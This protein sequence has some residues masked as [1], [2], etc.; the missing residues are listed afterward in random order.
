MN[1]LRTVPDTGLDY[2]ERQLEQKLHALRTSTSA[3][4]AALAKQYLDRLDQV[5]AEIARRRVSQ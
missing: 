5:R 4:G 1:E 3:I 2:L